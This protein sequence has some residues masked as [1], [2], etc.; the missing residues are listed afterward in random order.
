MG[1]V[2]D[3]MAADAAAALLDQHA[4]R[5]DTVTYTPN[6]GAA[7][8]LSDPMIGPERMSE[9]VDGERTVREQVRIVTLKLPDVASPQTKASVAIDGVQYRVR[10]ILSIDANFAELEVSRT[11]LAERA[12]PGYRRSP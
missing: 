11:A 6:G 5:S 4:E 8:T 1:S 7:V 12:R 10:S 3:T 2:H 9:R